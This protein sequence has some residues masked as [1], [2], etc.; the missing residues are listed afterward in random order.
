[1]AVPLPEEAV[2][3]APILHL[4][5]LKNHN[6]EKEKHLRILSSQEHKIGRSVFT[7]TDGVST[8]A[9]VHLSVCVPFSPASLNSQQ[10]SWLYVKLKREN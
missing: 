5:V 8:L 2:K 9:S 4:Q 6:I 7:R 10:L 3:A 1:M